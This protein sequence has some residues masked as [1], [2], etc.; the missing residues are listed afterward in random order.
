MKTKTSSFVLAAALLTASMPRCLAAAPVQGAVV[1]SAPNELQNGETAFRP[2]PAA[3]APNSFVERFLNNVHNRAGFSVGTTATYM[4]DFP[5][6]TGK[7]IATG[8]M[9]LSPRLFFTLGSRTQFRFDY[10][11]LYQRYNHQGIPAGNAQTATV[12]Y[13]HR[14]S[15]N[16][17]V[18][19]SNGLRSAVNDYG[20]T[21]GSSLSVVS[22]PN[23]GRLLYVPGLRITTDQVRVGLESRPGKKMALLVDGGYDFV[24]YQHSEFINTNGFEAGI[25]ASYQINRW[26]F[27]DNGFSHYF[28]PLTRE[29]GTNIQRVQAGNLKLQ[30][31]RQTVALSFGGD[32]ESAVYLGRRSTTGGGAVTFT[33]TSPSTKISARYHRGFTVALGPGT[34]VAGHDVGISVTRWLGRR[35]NLSLLS[36]Y[37]RGTALDHSKVQLISGSAGMEFSMGRHLVLSTQYKYLGQRTSQFAGAAPNVNSSTGSIGIEYFL[38]SLR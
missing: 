18:L 6:N 14:L 34:P 25:H 15:R 29:S 19:L 21:L 10:S 31:R 20:L 13:R 28:N 5:T 16:T 12:S 8:S 32:L 22:D 27:V 24:R 11:F 2:T 3:E 4:P 17:S 33:K 23:F 36:D 37:T 38:S 26:L 30:S 35:A 9:I 7:S 1:A